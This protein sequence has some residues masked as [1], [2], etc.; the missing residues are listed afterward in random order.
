MMTKLR[1]YSDPANA[2]EAQRI[3]RNAY[4]LV[5]RHHMPANRVEYVLDKTRD[6]LME[7]WDAAKR[8]KLGWA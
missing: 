3:A 4:E 6:K 7:H 5:L 8:K 2:A 1:Y